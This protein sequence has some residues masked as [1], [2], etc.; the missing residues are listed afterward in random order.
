MD[1]KL[2]FQRRLA[3]DKMLILNTSHMVKKKKNTHIGLKYI[4]VL[5][6]KKYILA[7]FYHILCMFLVST[8]LS[9]NIFF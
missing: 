9:K 2:D 5:L 4:L 7:H 3:M 6:K 8:I 1:G